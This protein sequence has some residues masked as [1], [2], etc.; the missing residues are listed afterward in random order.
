MRTLQTPIHH[1]RATFETMHTTSGWA[2]HSDTATA[3]NKRQTVARGLVLAGS[4]HVRV[5]KKLFRARSLAQWF[6]VS[7]TG[8]V[9]AKSNLGHQK[10]LRFA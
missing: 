2:L 8:S 6:L 10:P 5:V 1:H 9:E 3:A 4:F 7:L